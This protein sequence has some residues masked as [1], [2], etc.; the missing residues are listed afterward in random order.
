M[1]LARKDGK[2]YLAAMERDAG[3]AG[4]LLG[5]GVI[6]GCIPPLWEMRPEDFPLCGEVLDLAT[7]VIVHSAYVEVRLRERG[8]EGAVWKIPH[9]AWPAP[10][11]TPER[12]AGSPAARRFGNLNASKRVPQLLDAFARLRESH[13][14]AQL[15]LVGAAAP[16]VD[17]SGGSS[18]T[19][20]RAPS[21]T[22]TTSTSARLWAL[23][24]GV[25]VVVSLRSPT[26]GETSGTR[27]PRALARQ[28]P[29]RQRRRL[30]LRASR[31]RGAE[32]R[33]G[34]A[35]GRPL[36]DAMEASRIA[37]ARDVMGAARARSSPRREHGLEHVAELYAAALEEAAGGEAVRDAVLARSAS[38]QPTVGIEPGVGEAGVLGAHWTRSSLVTS[39]CAPRGRARARACG[40]VVG[41]ARGASCSSRPRSASRS[42]GAC[43][44]RGSWS[45][46]SSTPSSRRASPPA[47]SFLVRDQPGRLVRLRL[48]AAD[49]ARRTGSS[50][51]I[52]DAYAAAKAI[53]SVAMS[54]AAVPAYLLA[55]RVLRPGA[56]ARRRRRSPS[57]SRRSSTPAR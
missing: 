16:G 56:R 30:V 18:T 13:P 44:R 2:G 25:D 12:V 36:A 9:P 21:C 22:R 17:L 11:V 38:P 32:G 52:P 47:R 8:F 5:L 1:T 57:R 24:A 27:D 10:D 54:L 39:P 49:R 40:A 50:R 55:R 37:A 35:R 29:A 20:S 28:A 45:T 34:R 53:N 41:V 6:D 48:S 7:G 3:L 23:M 46:S 33:A 15:L 51:S 43:P 4:R 42:R 31:R 26:M 19:A 14:D